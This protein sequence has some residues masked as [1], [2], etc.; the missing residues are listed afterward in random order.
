MVTTSKRC[1]AR[2]LGL[3][4]PERSGAMCEVAQEQGY[5]IRAK[6]QS[7]SSTLRLSARPYHRPKRVRPIEVDQAMATTPPKMT[8]VMTKNAA[9][10]ARARNTPPAMVTGFMISNIFSLSPWRQRK[11][12]KVA[13][14]YTHLRAHETDS[15]L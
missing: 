4:K 2:N 9:V 8:S 6:L 11:R 3:N 5:I 1:D 14:S 15:Y 10:I 13:V 12:W 7:P